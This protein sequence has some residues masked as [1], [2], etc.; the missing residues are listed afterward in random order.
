MATVA[1]DVYVELRVKQKYSLSLTSHWQR[2]FLVFFA[3][4]DGS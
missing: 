1:M 2:V 3:S 4:E